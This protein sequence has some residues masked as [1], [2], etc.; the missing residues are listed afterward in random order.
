MSQVGKE[1]EIAVNIRFENPER[2]LAFEKE[3]PTLARRYK[4]CLRVQ[5]KQIFRRMC[6]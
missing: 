5:T 6:L 2:M 1:G 3:I 4:G